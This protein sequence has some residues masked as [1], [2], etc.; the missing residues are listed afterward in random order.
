MTIADGIHRISIHLLSGVLL[1]GCMVSGCKNGQ[2]TK[3]SPGEKKTAACFSCHGKNG[4]PKSP[5]MPKLAGQNRVYL[6]DAMKS[7]ADGRRDHP[8]MKSF[9]TGLSEQDLEDI[10]SFYASQRPR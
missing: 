3:A 2:D 4:I 6:I 8:L 1:I 7:Y 10:A 9:V 5:N